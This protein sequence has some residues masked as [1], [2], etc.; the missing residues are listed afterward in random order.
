MPYCLER[1]QWVSAEIWYCVGDGPIVT[2]KKQYITD[3]KI[4]DRLMES[5]SPI[6][7]ENLVFHFADKWNR[8][9]ITLANGTDAMLVLAPNEACYYGAHRVP[10]GIRLSDEF[11]KKLIEV[12]QENENLPVHIYYDE[13]FDVENQD[14]FLEPAINGWIVK[15]VFLP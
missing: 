12:L 5:F 3:R 15:Q 7:Y 8:V 6:E 4:L 9:H 13:D 1:Y 14:S 10:I 2:K 11:E